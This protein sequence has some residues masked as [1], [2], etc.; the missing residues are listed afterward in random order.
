M[1]A[2]REA[3]P[4]DCDAIG[5]VHV[6]AWR[7]TY[8]RLLPDRMLAELSTQRRAAM[9]RRGLGDPDRLL[10]VAEDGG[11]VVVGFGACWRPPWAGRSAPAE[12]CRPSTSW[13]G[14]NAR[15]PAAP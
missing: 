9:W 15:A 7:E 14:H 8:A 12:R 13:A 3:A 2:V 11:G 6:A 10:L 4:D 5:G 1:A